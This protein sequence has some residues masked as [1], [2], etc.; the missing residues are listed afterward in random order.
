MVAPAVLK[1]STVEA[2]NCFNNLGRVL[3]DAIR[4]AS[5]EEIA[6]IATKSDLDFRVPGQVMA[7]DN[8][9]SNKPDFAVLKQV[10]EV[11][12]VLFDSETSNKRKALFMWSL[13][14]HLR[15]N[16]IPVVYFQ[17][18]ADDAEWQKSAQS[19]GVE[20]VSIVP[21]LRFKLTLSPTPTKEQSV[22]KEQDRLVS[23]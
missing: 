11:D 4:L 12:P 1:E 18:A 8:H 6:S 5:N 9:S 19:F 15:L 21:E 20:Q 14:N 17:I 10:F 7:F 16:G 2:I 23:E 3:V 13:M 22:D